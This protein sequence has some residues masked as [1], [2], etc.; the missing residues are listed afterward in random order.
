MRNVL[1][2]SCRV[3]Q[4]TF[5]IQKFLSENRGVYQ[6]ICKKIGTARQATHENVTRRG[7]DTICMPAN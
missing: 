5:Y 4:N 3:N 6:I 7:R 2:K 1:D